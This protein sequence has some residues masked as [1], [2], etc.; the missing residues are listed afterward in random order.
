M[1]TNTTLET[2]NRRFAPD[3]RK[4]SLQTL[5]KCVLKPRRSLGRRSEDRRYPVTDVFDGATLTLAILLLS[6]SLFDAIFTLTLLS[7]GGTELN[8]V[9][10]YF[11]ETGGSSAFLL[12]KLLLTAIPAI[13][14]VATNNLLVFGRW[15][16]RSILAALVGAY[17]GL[18][19]YELVLLSSI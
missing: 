12:A 6:F 3:R 2:A 8:P 11:L 1:L 13:I 16:V 9:M 4:Y 19:V 18:L 10:R 14:L 17:A 7:H 5:V 15:R